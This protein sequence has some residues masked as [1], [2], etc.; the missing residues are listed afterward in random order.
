V[1][2]NP[3]GPAKLLGRVLRIGLGP[4]FISTIEEAGGRVRWRIKHS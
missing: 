1:G 2:S 3:T 4:A